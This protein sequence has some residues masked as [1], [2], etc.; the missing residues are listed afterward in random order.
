MTLQRRLIGMTVVVAL[1]SVTFT[2]LTTLGLYRAGASDQASTALRRDAQTV[3]D[4]LAAFDDRPARLRA[5]TAA[6]TKNL[7]RRQITLVVLTDP[8]AP[9]DPPFVAGDGEA[10][11]SPA[12]L[13]DR[14]RLDGQEWLAEGVTENG[15]TVLVTEPAAGASGA[16]PVGRRFVLALLVGLA[17]GVLVGSLLARQLGAPLRR[18]AAGAREI[19]AGRR[20]VQ[21]TPG[22]PAEV[23][24][25]GHALNDLAAA[26]SLSEERQR[27]FLM[28]VSH[29]LRT[30]LTAVNGYAEGLA[31]GVIVGF[32]AERAGVVIKQESARL[33]RRV[34]DLMALAR[35]EA[36][37][38]TV[39]PAPADLADLV[40]AAGA[41][42]MARAT[43]A[44][45]RLD[46]AAPATLPL[47]TDADRLRQAIDALLDNALRVLPPE[48]RLK[49]TC[50]EHPGL[51]WVEVSDDG[52][53]L[54]DDDLAVAFER[55]R[56][57]DRY[58]G[59]RAVSTGL[60]LALVGEL[61]RR[62]GGQAKAGHSSAGG[63]SFVLYL[64]RI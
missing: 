29:E 15:I 62:L 54:A 1:I 9:V 37:D 45:V 56:L 4:T 21:V 44:R 52:P 27:R 40:R 14:R 47:V 38:F 26:L 13:S 39:S 17:A 25:V 16:S 28:D 50:G 60:G 12:G 19:G 48:S 64:P 11:R 57:S 8:A 2:S 24:D 6:L 22:G 5:R 46:V 36:D 30:P 20:D 55:G 58:S 35:M 33:S 61:V 53:G 3:A 59:E 23:A 42:W 41:A 7:A 43:D 63:A 31:D 10:A 49:L 32:E 34:E 18:L 51:A